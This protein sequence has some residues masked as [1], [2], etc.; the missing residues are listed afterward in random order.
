LAFEWEFREDI[1]GENNQYDIGND[2]YQAADTVK[3]GKINA[4]SR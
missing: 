4:F 3:D 1:R 2:V